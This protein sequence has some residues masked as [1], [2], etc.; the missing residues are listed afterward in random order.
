MSPAADST[1]PTPVNGN[2]NTNW[3]D[4]YSFLTSL[5]GLLGGP[6]GG[7]T[8]PGAYPITIPDGFEPLTPTDN[9]GGIS[10]AHGFSGVADWRFANG[11]TN[12][13]GTTAHTTY[14]SAPFTNGVR[15]PP[16]VNPPTPAA[17]NSTTTSTGPHKVMPIAIIGMSCRLPGSI[18][19]PAEFWELIARARGTW[20]P[21]PEN[22]FNMAPFQHPNPGKA[23]T[24]NPVGGCFLNTDFKAFDAPF[25]SLTEKEAI[26]LDPQQ[27][28]LLE[29]SFEALENAG[30]PKQNIV[31][32]DVG[33]FIGG[34]FPEY[35]S[36]LFRD[37]DTIP[38]HQATGCAYAMQS[39]RISHF[40]DLRGPSFTTDTACSSSLVALHTACQSLRAGESSMALVGG[41]HLNMLPEF[42][43]SFSKSRLFSDHGRSISFDARGTGF[44]RGEGC[45]IL[46][47]KPLDQ[48]I[49]DRDS[50]RAVIVG[51]G[52]NQDG[53]TPGI[54]MPNGEA[55]E[56]LMR[57][58]YT[59][60]GLDPNDCGYVEAHGTGTKVGDPIEARAI[61][62]VLAQK[63]SP[64]DPLL[65]GS[66]KS[67]I[68]HLEG[69]SGI[70]AV[71]KAALM[72]ERGFIIPN[73][74]FKIPNPKI[75]FAEWGIKVPPGQRPWPRNKKYVSVNNFGFG[76]TN[77]H[78]VLERGPFLAQR[79]RDRLFVDSKHAFSTNGRKLFIFSANDKASL[80]KVTKELVIYLEQ[81]PEMFELDL[82]ANVAYTIC[83]RRSILQWRLAVPASN[84]F[85][86]VEQLSKEQFTPGKET[87]PLRIGFIFTGQGAQWW[88][89][90]R[91]LYFDY[92]V[93]RDSL[94]RADTCMTSMGANWSLIEELGK[95]AATSQVNQAHISQP[96]CTAIQLALTDLLRSWGIEPYAVAGHS[97]GEIAA[98]YAAGILTFDA[99]MTIAYHRGRLIPVLKS[100]HP[101]LR[102]AMMAVG[103]SKEEFAPLLAD[104]KTG[105]ARI[106]CFNSPSSLTIS[107]DEPAITELEK[108]VQEKG[109]FNRRLQV[110]V[111][112]HSHHM[113]LVAKEYQQALRNVE[114][115]VST[116][117]KFHSSLLGRLA[118]GTELEP[119]YWVQNLTCSVRFAE[120]VDDMVQPFGEYKTGVN[121]LVELGPHSALQGP[122]KQILKV[123]GANAAKIPYASAL[124]RKRDAVE[125]A[126]ELA[127]NVWMK[128]ATLNFEAINFPKPPAKPPVLLTDLP[129]Y[130]W[131][132]QTEYWHRSRMWEKHASRSA[133][134]TDILGTL[135]NYSNDL[136][137]TWRN[138][139]R[140]DDL[141]W[142]RH[143]QIQSLTI[144]PLA[145]YITMALEAATQ[146]AQESDIAFDKFELQNVTVSAPLVLPDEDVEMNITIRTVEEN[147]WDEFRICS[148][149]ASQGWKDHCKGLIGLRT[150]EVNSVNGDK[151]TQDTEATLRASIAEIDAAAQKTI[152]TT[153]MYDNLW[154]LGVAYGPTFQGIESC[155][156]ASGYSSGTLKVADVA[157]EM[158]NGH[159]V[160][161][162]I[163]P[164]FLESLI[165]MYWP[166]L[167]SETS[168]ALDTIYLPSS[169][170]RM[171]FSK[172]VIPLIK[173]PN[174]TLQA[175][176]RGSI[177]ASNPKPAKVS[178]FATIAD[179][180]EPLITLE[181]LTVAPILDRKSQSNGNAAREL[182]YKM[183]WEPI[184]NPIHPTDDFE[185]VEPLESKHTTEDIVIIHGDSDLQKDT[186]AKLAAD[187]EE[188]TGKRP[189]LGT[190]FE[191][192]ASGKICIFLNELDQSVLTT[193]T[194]EQ[195]T[196]IQKII[197]SVQGILWV[198]RGALSGCEN[199]DANMVVGMSRSIR[200]ETLLRFA[201]LDLDS[202]TRLSDA[203]SCKAILEV[204]KSAFG[205][206]AS[207]S[208]ELEF[209]ERGGAF[210]TPRIV[211]DPEMNEFVHRQ[212]KEGVLEPTAFGQEGRPLKMVV[213]A[214]GVLESLHFVDD[215]MRNS[216]LAEDEIEIEVKAIGMNHRDV[217]A[218]T[219]K[220][221]NEEFGQE[222]SGIVTAVG[223]AVTDI[224]I[225]DRVAALASNALASYART[226][227]HLILKIPSEMTFES[228]ASLPVA[229]CTA[230]YS[231]IELARLSEGEKILIHA[232]AG[233][234][235]QAAI[236]IAQMVGAEVFATVGSAE[237][238]EHLISKFGVPESHIYYSRDASFVDALRHQ[239]GNKGVDVV[240]NSLRGPVARESWRCLDK[241]GRYI[242]LVKQ[243]GAN[244][245]NVEMTRL[246]ENITFVTVDM[247]S[248]ISERPKL[249]KKL[250]SEVNKLLQEG[251]AKT[252]SPAN[253]FSIS[254][255]DEAFKTLQEG[256][257]FG[258][259]VI[260]PKADDTVQAPAQKLS[261]L[262]R[263][264]ATYVLIGGTGGLGRGLAKWMI[265]QGAKS[266]VL[267]SRSGTSTGKVAELIED[268]K[269][270]GA[271][272]TVRACNVVD[273]ASV[274]TLLSTGVEGLPPVRGVV[275]GSMVLRDVL[276][277]K[278]THAEWVDVM[279]SKVHG[280]WNFHRALAN[281]PLDFFITF[282]SVAASVGNRGQAAYAAANAFLNAF[283][284]YRRALGLA[285][286]SI[287]PTAISD[288]GYLAENAEA[289]AEVAKNLGSDMI[290]EA[291]VLALAGAAINGQLEKAC[292]S[293]V[294]TG[295]RMTPSMQPFWTQDAKFKHLREVMEAQ[296][297][298]EATA[299]SSTAISY[300]AALKAAK[301]PE[302]R[303]EV[304]C[305]GLVFKIASV[306]MMEEEELDITRSLSHYPLDSLVAIEIRN[307]ITREF[308]ANLQVLEL[309]S[310][311]SIQTLSK[312]VCGKSK[313]IVV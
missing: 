212:T 226:K 284:Q 80:Q 174:S 308:E 303:E 175:Y 262:L 9:N 229:Y 244:T 205:C 70:V 141:P 179:A 149:T 152:D 31:G 160:S 19:S 193:V 103:G 166:I 88:A 257:F 186:A 306:L 33:V 217:L 99:C 250:V 107:G 84:S 288:I 117:V 201:T 120:A 10:S 100:K 301:T 148:W 274:D 195:F 7:S 14:P 1:P 29:C 11:H 127:A 69:A 114:R 215:Q 168:S 189:E 83:Q 237:K 46:I 131:N 134:R 136:E 228:A 116:K 49:K 113:N 311:G 294:I 216:D 243:D 223:A 187:L 93:F 48:A 130:P 275:H 246:Q 111:A 241:F 220:L 289:A 41:C 156:A 270:V 173:E 264:D 61:H 142:L 254:Q 158:P 277:E 273:R 101:D 214:T 43:I 81:R 268:A 119:S 146:R 13:N 236:A 102:G 207:A 138:I 91:E 172:D 291:E 181:D 203:D 105:E 8:I 122:V 290:C 188:A 20:S 151:L 63:R 85:E 211:N 266:L 38:M 304:V 4:D 86:L 5:E 258:K 265:G 299:S 165:E 51:S 150:K 97:S 184:L 300:S 139:V 163:N 27:R 292:N 192:N 251:K 234:V 155:K 92:P 307:F 32:K 230:Y 66:V 58:V 129:R 71:M 164:S 94:D 140:L 89:M 285:A 50:I 42:W 287:D 125:T 137:P 161:P 197:T 252:P 21:I 64:R 68:G 282:S 73:H 78:V 60:S 227:S 112:Y 219:G 225:G 208:S 182:C 23:G 55:Q 110:D 65:I 159:L 109:L 82:M 240:L 178:M 286:S 213:G 247:F 76:G 108:V 248:V 298:A 115:P 256:S 224:H 239:T 167:A 305:K 30:V 302:E 62:N 206:R 56:A 180:K 37:T 124:V 313:L 276:F 47:L 26:S 204:F 22:R 132:Y 310:S 198:I 218:V 18:S 57:Q 143:H 169:I 118:D 242:E 74:D 261:Q 77:A 176:C 293:H 295:V 98:A 35:E 309:L 222:A 121:M 238:K 12:G 255:T 53:K 171:T 297:A 145:G 263:P 281:Q 75:P 104:L 249:I 67:N 126:L 210:F 278:M 106:A 185:M 267:V 6:V 233:A 191:N 34:S 17:A 90:G 194:P 280:A 96:A 221:P 283:V 271:T 79:G 269:K 2:G 260:A 144:F 200:S 231:V 133:P 52:I 162:I 3:Q 183:E 128:G 59:N 28:L 253:T 190:L 153:K 15:A 54:T 87:E 24:H 259:V 135:A 170:G 157:K 202:K 147:V 95:D 232:A 45:A 44:G 25:F 40:F 16:A 245:V 196:A 296:A 209:M 72:L 39:N 279:E 154:T 123:A 235:G 177:S 272:V 36:A 312:G 199:P